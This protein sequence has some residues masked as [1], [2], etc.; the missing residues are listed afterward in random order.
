MTKVCLFGIDGS[1]PKLIFEQ[2]ID[3]LPNI[4]KLMRSGTYAKINST[5][6]PATIIAWNAMISG[7][8]ASEI[9][10]FSYTYKDKDGKSR[11]VSSKNVRC[12]M[13]WD[14][15]TEQDKKTVSLYVPLTYPV[16][17]INGCMISGFLTPGVDTACAYPESIKEKLK[18][19]EHP[20]IFFDIGA[21][22][23]AHKSLDVDSLLE[24]TYQMTKMQV[25][26]LKDILVN[27]EWDLFISVMIGSDR[28]QHMLWRHFDENHRR[29]IP[30]SPYRN[31]LK[32]YY[33][34]LDQKLGEVLELLDEDTV[35]L[36][37]SDHGMVRQEGK[38]NINNWLIQ[39]GYMFLT[40]E[41]IEEIEENK[42]IGKK[43]RIRYEGIDMKKTLAYGAGAYNGRI[44]L[45]KE[46]LGDNYQQFREELAAKI[47]KIKGDQGQELKTEIFKAEEIYEDSSSPEC[48]DLTVYFDE[49]RWASN[50]DFGAEGLY[51]WETAMGADSAGHSKQGCFIVSGKGIPNLDQ[52]DD[53]DI[54]QVAP[55]VL[56][57]LGVGIP[58]DITVKALDL[59]EQSGLLNFSNSLSLEQVS[60]HYQEIKKEFQEKDPL[61]AAKNVADS[62][63][64]Q[65]EFFQE[66][67]KFLVE[68]FTG[69]YRHDGKTPLAFHSTFLT[70]LLYLCGEKTKDALL[71][72]A[73][74]DLL[75]DTD[76]SKEQLLSQRFMRGRQYLIQLLELLTENTELSREPDENNLPPRY[77]EFISR[78]IG[79]KREVIN[80]EISDRFC[81]LMD[82]EGVLCLPPEEKK[83]RLVAKLLKVNSFVE[84]IIRDRQDVN[85][86]CLKLFRNKVK[87]IEGSYN[88]ESK[89]AVIRQA[90]AMKQ[91][92]RRYFPE[93]T[94]IDT[95]EGIQCKVYANSH[96]D[97]FVI[98][99]PKYIPQDLVAF[100]GLKKRFILE[101]DMTRFNLFNAKEVVK[102][103]LERLKTEFPYFMYQCPK[104]QNWFLTVPLDRIKTYH[105]PKEGVRQLMQLSEKDLDPYLK[106]TKQLLEL[107]SQSGVSMA[108]IGVSHSTLL[109]NYTPG[110]SDI[111]ILVFGKENGWK[112]IKHMETIQHPSLKWKTEED[113][114]KYYRDRI[115]SRQF[116][117]DEYVFNMV[118][119]KDDGFFDGNVFSIF[120]VEKEDEMWYDWAEEHHSLATV[121]VQATVCDTYNS[122]LRPGYYGI[123]NSI[124]LEGYEDVPIER[125]VTWSRPF[126]LQARMN[127]QV[128]AVGLLEKVKRKSG[129][130][131][132]QIVIGYFDTYTSERGEKEY[133]K[134]LVK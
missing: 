67:F 82:L 85:E 29:S 49:L 63:G 101:K 30:D 22:L 84:N 89:V 108:D 52:I 31:A 14:I 80:A 98:V 127:D 56:K 93:S 65:G 130:E 33:I 94:L 60:S 40:E 125:I 61:V 18:K 123:K 131:Y 70:K 73:L 4:R 120:V 26:I 97:G 104:H 102:E 48:P 124:V 39:E 15:L 83:S 50:P 88:V 54:K 38:I 6:P 115:V 72:G 12:K 27:E 68:S 41:F 74:H 44:F 77:Q 32:D 43:T 10:V 100:N 20:E 116:N 3:D 47:K 46:K 133:L 24:K 1:P 51:S 64:K 128:E 13:L 95:F 19:L 90:G 86:N 107:I 53:I 91:I 69:K 126:V 113:W 75:E 57:L 99:K 119:K 7:K 34:Y 11:L 42:K 121:K 79:A 103:N 36:V 134:A 117:E 37:V 81:D 114:A 5:I 122:H 35:V 28:L 9:G 2:W 21:G 8:D 111:D 66:V 87:N 55:T 132:Y 112:V 76:V 78:L 110:K 16:R 25:E 17:P 58:S 23:A 59:F 71:V 105:D 109:G 62:L 129:E 118:R 106:S 45:S 92:K 96:P